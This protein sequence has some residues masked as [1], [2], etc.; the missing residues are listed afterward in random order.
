MSDETGLT[1]KRDEL[2][3][4][5]KILKARLKEVEAER[6]A[7]RERADKAEGEFRRVTIDDPVEAVLADLFVV[8]LRHVMGE[9][10]EHFDFVRDDAGALQMRTKAGE[11]VKLSDGAEVTF[12]PEAIRKAL[13]EVGTLDE[14]VRGTL[15]IGGGAP[16]GKGGQPA[17]TGPVRRAPVAQR[18]GLR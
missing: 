2:L 15:A 7:E 14:V 5:V 13:L 11:P 9:V 10:R 4:E 3:A 18:F 8:P 17:A 12:E 16:G 1:A 6:D